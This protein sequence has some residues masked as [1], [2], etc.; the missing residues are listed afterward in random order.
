V[1]VKTEVHQCGAE[2]TGPRVGRNVVAWRDRCGNRVRV[3]AGWVASVRC[4]QHR[5]AEQAERLR[6]AL[7]GER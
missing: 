5:S 4:H 7:A 1:K 3:P 2:V 6:A